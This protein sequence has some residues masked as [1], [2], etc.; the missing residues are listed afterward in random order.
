MTCGGVLRCPNSKY[1]QHAQ[2]KAQEELDRVVGRER[3]PD[4]NDES[5]LPYLGVL[6]EAYR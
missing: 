3:L 6:K 4:L 1:M 2:V 5:D